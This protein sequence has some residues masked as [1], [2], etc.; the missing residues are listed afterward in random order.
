MKINHEKIL[1]KI[2][3]LLALSESSN[4]NEAA[5]ATSMAS[6]MMTKYNIELSD[7]ILNES[8]ENISEETIKQ[9]SVRNIPK[10]KQWIAIAA[11]ELYECKTRIIQNEYGLSLSVLGFK[12]DVQMAIWTY[13]YL[14]NE[15]NRLCGEEIKVDK[16]TGRLATQFK[17]SFK[18]AASSAIYSK[19]KKMIIEKNTSYEASGCKG[20]VISKEKMIAEK[21]G[22][23]EYKKQRN[24]L[25]YEAYAHSRGH[26]AGSNINI[27]VK[28]K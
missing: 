19:I 27:N 5:S 12:Q 9:K 14:E 24:S 15:I 23:I 21:F 20:L 18:R 22:K 1:L 13:E 3:K 6:K 17:R 4:I 16:L 11:G 25:K 26:A 10:W 7:T 8:N 2:K 28:L